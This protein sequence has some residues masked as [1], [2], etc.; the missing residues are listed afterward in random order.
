MN[1]TSITDLPIGTK[2]NSNIPIQQQSNVTYKADDITKPIDTKL[3]GGVSLDQNTINKIVSGLQE[4]SVTGATQL[5]SR[6][7]PINKVQFMD[8]QVQQEYIPSANVK[9]DF[10]EEE[11]EEEDNATIINNYSK[12]Q[13]IL[14]KIENMYSDIQMPILIAI[15]YFLFQLPFIKSF[16]FQNIP[17]LYFKDG[18]IN[19][20]GQLF[21]S[22]LF[23]IIYYLASI[24][25]SL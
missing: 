6:D 7:I 3:G 21:M 16:L 22:I 5:Q 25:L 12:Q 14:S 4:A 23:G 17:F 9:K 20:Y 15:L 1:T 13:S 2:N 8:E 10:V 18:N 19:I 24:L 11:D